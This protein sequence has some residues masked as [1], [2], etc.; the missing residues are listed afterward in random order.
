MVSGE[1]FGKFV[2][3]KRQAKGI[4]LRE[5][6][7][8]VE[9]SAPYLS[10]IER[11]EYP[12]PA[13]DRVKKIAQII[14]CDPDDLLARADRVSSDLSQIIKKRPVQVAA[15]LR[16]TP[17]LTADHMAQLVRWMREM[18]PDPRF[19][20]PKLKMSS[21]NS[22]WLSRSVTLS[23]PARLPV[24]TA[25]SSSSP[26]PRGERELSENM[27]ITDQTVFET[28]DFYLACFLRGTGYDLVDLREKDG[29]K[30]FV[31]RD[32]STRRDD[33]LAFYSE[34]AVVV[35]LAFSSTISDMRALLANG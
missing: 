16:A 35:A 24:C 30:V 3:Q 33:V 15:L 18:R 10:K 2:R 8:M 21:K 19:S 6:A 14:D 11:D 27:R 17:D 1:R 26:D 12:P 28:G 22:N 7:K 34:K 20:Q 5:L 31:F 32:R 25:P 23:S 9:V 13:E 4:G 29:R